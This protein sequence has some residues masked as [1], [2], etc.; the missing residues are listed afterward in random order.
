MLGVE[1]DELILECRELEIVIFFVDG[2][3]GASAIRAR[4]A[5][6]DGVD[7][8]FVGDA[9]LAGVSAFVDESVIAN[10][11]PERLHSLLVA[12]GRG[13]DEIVVGETHAIPERAKLGGDFIGELL[14]RFVGGLG[15]AFDFLSVLVGAGQE[16]GIIAQHAM[17]AGD[18]VASDGRVSMADVRMRVDVID[19]GRDVELFGHEFRSNSIC[20]A[21]IVE[22]RLAASL[23]RRETGQA[24]SLQMIHFRAA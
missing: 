18:G 2:F 22:T 1:A 19:R 3:G 8:E 14:R 13:A 11:A 17:T 20:R 23:L 24:P 4:S 9:V 21:A 7:V 6:A 12:R 16:P 15:G 10:L 5:G